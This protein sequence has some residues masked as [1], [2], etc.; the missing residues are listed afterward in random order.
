MD[1]NRH[2]GRVAIITGAASGIGRA[3]CLRLAAEGAVVV[4]TDIETAGLAETAKT[5]V[6][7]GGRAHQV[8]GDI[9]DAV[10]IRDVV[11]TARRAGG[12]DIVANVAGIMDHFVPVD[13]V[14]DDDWNRVLDVD[15]NAPMRL[16]RSVI[17]DLRARGRG[18]I[19]NVSSVAGLRG[20]GSGAA[21]HAAKHGLIGLTRHIAYTYRPFGIRCNAV[22]PGGVT[23]GIGSS[24]SPTVP[25]AFERMQLSL[26]LNE[27][28]AEPDEIA[29]LISWLSSDEASNVNGAIVPADGGWTAG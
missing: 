15:L 2:R 28:T 6:A 21:Y 22:S 5:I 1:T 12:I 19:V 27:R 13:E 18:S 8:G 20:G 29:A 17:P 14:I 11:E 16:C 3:T 26:A 25:W 24:A 9:T 10:V 7:D 4:T 23:T